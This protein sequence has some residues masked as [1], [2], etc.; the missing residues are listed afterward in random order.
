[1]RYVSLLVLLMLILAGCTTK[2]DKPAPVTLFYEENAQVEIISSQG[3]RVL[4]D[5]YDP[6]LLSAPATKNDVLLTTHNHSDHQNG[7]FLKS[8]TGQ[9]L[10]IREGEIALED[11]KIRGIASAHN[12]GLPLK[13]EGGSNYIYIVDVDGLRIVHFGDIG[14][15]ELTPDQLEALGTVDIAIMQLAN[16]FSSVDVKNK[17]GFNLMAQ[18]KPKV[19]IPTHYN[20]AALEYALQLW[21][22]FYAGKQ[23]TFSRDQLTDETRLLILGG[24][25]EIYQKTYALQTWQSG[26]PE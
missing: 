6:Q 3:T 21:P 5:I 8:F 15:A 18:V 1:M 25:G 11:V 14:Q 13:P 10:L 2:P 9:Q 23:V 17:I 26:A 20:K 7:K 24:M 4:M 16:S 19:I 22:G 12:D